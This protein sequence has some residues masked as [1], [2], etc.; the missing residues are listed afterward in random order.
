MAV[1]NSIR[2]RGVFLIII[3]ALALFAFVLDGVINKGTSG[4]KGE[5]NVA[6]VNGTDLPREEFMKQV[7]NTQRAMGQGQPISQAINLVYDREVRKLLLK[8]QFEALGLSTERDQ[9]N[10]AFAINLANNP[11]FQNDEGIYDEFKLQEYIADIKANSPMDY[12]AWVEYE[13]SVEAGILEK[14]YFNMVRGGLISTLA[15]GEQEYRFQNDKINIEYVQ[16][17]YTKI[18]DEDVPVSDEEIATYIKSHPKEFEIEPIVDI[19]Y[20]TFDEE[21][22]PADIDE[23]RTEIL[24]LLDDKVEYNSVTN[25]N[26]TIRGFAR[27]TDNA[28]FVNAHSEAGYVDK[29]LYN[30]DLKKDIADT[31]NTIG[32]NEIYGPYKVENTY[33]LTKLVAKRQLP[34]S[35]KARHILISYVGSASANAEVTRTEEEAEKLADSILN[36][37]RISPSKFPDLVTEY[38]ADQGSINNEGRYD[39]FVYGAMV[40]EFRD[41]C[42]EN[43]TGDT[44]VVKTAFGFHIIEIEG[45]KNFQDVVKIATITKEIEPSEKTLG[46]VF[47]QAANFELD[48]Q[49]GDFNALATEKG[50]K[51]NP[52]NKI[53]ELD[54]TIPGIGNNRQIVNWAFEES[55]EVG[56][57]RRFS[58]NDGYVIA[59]LT[60]KN[61]R[62]LLSVAEASAIVTPRV[63]NEKKAKMIRESITGTTLQEMATSQNVTVKTASALTMANPTIAGAG[64][65]PKVVGAAFGKKAGETTK[66]IDGKDG[67]YVVRVLAVNKAPDLQDY[68]NYANQLNS[69][70]LPSINSNV[71]NALKNAADIEDNRADFY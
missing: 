10:D 26:D 51:V 29:W 13:K 20:I 57:I 53:G 59:Q 38:S 52:M 36:V 35:V 55:T 56:D 63:R 42:F 9:L 17:P 32:I 24:K 41:F 50:L 19:Q 46:E 31:I 21:P 62:G 39:W 43:K 49:N 66:L 70:I 12:E 22:S 67:V 64:N 6:T 34:D 47:S 15:E 23:A 1:L 68:S 60:R 33:N 3:I 27:T 8:E 37:I 4:P 40:T 2:K 25:S 69:A 11:S 54:A 18:A 61:P 5:A 30:S 14:N 58:V 44:D 48:S 71:Y 28:D 65:E 16:F 45:Q 7:E